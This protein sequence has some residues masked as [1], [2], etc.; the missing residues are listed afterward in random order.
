[1][2]KQRLIKSFTEETGIKVLESFYLKG[3]DTP[4]RITKAGNIERF[5][6]CI[7]TDSSF[8]VIDLVA[9]VDNDMVSKC[10]ENL[11]EYKPTDVVKRRK[12]K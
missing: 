7:W 10:T 3:Y 11:V 4:Y 8:A 5:M 1:M 12:K 6:K 2:L 9:F